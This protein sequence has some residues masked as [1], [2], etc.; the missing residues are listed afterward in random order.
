[1]TTTL[2]VAE[3]PSPAGPLTLALHRGRLCALTFSDDWPRLRRRLVRRFGSVAE[4]R[5]GADAAP[6]ARRLND[7]F[8]GDLGALGAVAVDAGGTSFQR[9]VWSALRRI[10]PGET[11]SYAELARGIGCPGAARAV[12]AANGANPVALVIPC[13]RVIGADG[14]LTGY[15]AGVRRK[16]WLLAHEGGPPRSR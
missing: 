13:H 3:L 4:R 11:R 5:S 10:P 2:T 12:G 9:R 16:R 15:A 1:M 6:V 14:R 8:A 7:Y